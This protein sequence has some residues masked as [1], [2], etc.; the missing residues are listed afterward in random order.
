MKIYKID[1]EKKAFDMI[2]KKD[3]GRKKFIYNISKKNWNDALNYHLSIDSEA[4]GFKLA[5]NMIINLVNKISEKKEK[6]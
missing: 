5:G 3:D 1:N 6:Q 4:S 2:E